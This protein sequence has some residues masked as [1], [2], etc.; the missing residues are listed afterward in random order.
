MHKGCLRP[1][2]PDVGG[3]G[4]K[5]AVSDERVERKHKGENKERRWEMGTRMRPEGKFGQVMK[6]LLVFLIF[7]SW[8]KT[9]PSQQY[10][11]AAAAL[12]LEGWTQKC[13]ESGC[14]HAALL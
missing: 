1:A 6:Y 12:W 13:H 7:D 9:V 4:F 10:R 3:V 2:A 8:Q 14:A 5:A 11:L